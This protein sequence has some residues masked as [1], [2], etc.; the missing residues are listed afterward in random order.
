[1]IVDFHSHI[2]PAADHGS[3][4]L[5]TSLLQVAAAQHAG[6]DILC[7]TPH[8]Y[9][10]YEE[11]DAFLARRARCTEE[12]LRALPADAP[13]IRVGAEV[14]LCRGLHHMPQLD[15]LCL[16]GTRVLLLELPHVSSLTSYEET[17]RGLLE[18]RGLTVVLAH[19][20]RYPP[21]QIDPLLEIGF[22]AQLNADA[23]CDFRTRR[24]CLRNA[25]DERVVALGSD[26]HGAHHGYSNFHRAQ[27]I[28]A[29]RAIP[30]LSRTP[31]LLRQNTIK[32]T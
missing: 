4:G 25:Q 30:L 3:D 24:R 19:I 23:F 32:S 28:L 27:T 13:T 12:L 29:A 21:K 5:E 9:P 31:T 14:Q 20:D 8:F 18:E 6:V 1:M 16:S 26:I 15:S 7:A 10:R 11:A 22:L 17:L 2:L